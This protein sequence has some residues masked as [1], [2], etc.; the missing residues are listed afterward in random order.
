ML[1]PVVK[2]EYNLLKYVIFPIQIGCILQEKNMELHDLKKLSSVEKVQAME[3][4]WE[5]LNA[6]STPIT[7]PDWHQDIL[8][9]RGQLL[10]AGKVKTLSLAELKALKNK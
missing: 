1:L 4:L 10:E 2:K 9:E 5:E 8:A 6:A 7:S 3:M